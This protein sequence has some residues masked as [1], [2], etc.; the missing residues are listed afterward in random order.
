M[1]SPLLPFSFK[2]ANCDIKKSSEKTD[3]VVEETNQRLAENVY[4]EEFI[5]SGGID[6]S[7][8]P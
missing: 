3:D 6:I 7:A 4:T 2:V 1:N 8:K 5:L